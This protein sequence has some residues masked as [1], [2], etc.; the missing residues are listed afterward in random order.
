MLLSDNKFLIPSTINPPIIT[1][2]IERGA[3]GLEEYFAKHNIHAFITS[4]GRTEEHQLD[5]IRMYCK[6]KGVDVEFPAIL[7][8][9]VDELIQFG[10]EPIPAWLPALNRLLQKGIMINPPRP[11]NTLWDYLRSDSTARPAGT[12]LDRS[13]HQK[14]L[15]P[16]TKIAALDIGEGNH[17][18]AEIELPVKEALAEKKIIELV[19]CRFEAANR[20]VHCDLREA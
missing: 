18:L 16:G 10:D 17:S 20:A 7:T 9:T 1:P 11:V 4:G 2:L 19:G 6:Q 12:H 13:E 8:C 5:I 15:L 3:V 14:A